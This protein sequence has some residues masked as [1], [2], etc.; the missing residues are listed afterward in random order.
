MIPRSRVFFKHLGTRPRV[1][2][3]VLMGQMARPTI[4]IGDA[5]AAAPGG[6]GNLLALVEIRAGRDNGVS[7]KSGS[8]TRSCK[9]LAL[10]SGG[11]PRHSSSGADP[12]PAAFECELSEYKH[13]AD[14]A[15]CG[16]ASICSGANGSD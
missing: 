9:R 4:S 14:S 16:N 11:C 3:P 6:S 2:A 15:D 5:L 1:I 12:D 13:S 8:G 7:W 10:G